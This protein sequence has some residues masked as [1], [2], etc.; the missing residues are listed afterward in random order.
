MTPIEESRHV[1]LKIWLNCKAGSEFDQEL[2]GT[3]IAAAL[4]ARSRAVWLEAARVI[5]LRVQHY[6]RTRDIKRD[7]R[8]IQINESEGCRDWC[9]EQAEVVSS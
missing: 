3:V 8:D 5:D 7:V 1:A 9:K 2:A 6:R 4:A